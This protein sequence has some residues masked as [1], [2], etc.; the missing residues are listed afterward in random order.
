MGD[1]HDIVNIE[2]YLEGIYF[3]TTLKG[4]KRLGHLWNHTH[5]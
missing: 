4:K 1:H 3:E 2:D 5:N